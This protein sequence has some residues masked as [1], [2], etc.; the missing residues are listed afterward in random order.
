LGRTGTALDLGSGG[1][2]DTHFLIQ[3]GFIVTAVDAAPNANTYIADLKTDDLNF[4]YSSFENFNF[5]QYDL[6]NSSYSLPFVNQQ[7]FPAVWQNIRTAL[8]PSGL[9]VGE[10]FGIHDPWNNFD[11]QMNFHT[12]QDIEQL[13]NG[14]KIHHLVEEE[15]DRPTASGDRKHW[16]VFHIIAQKK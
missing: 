4:V 5:N 15:N 6:I 10:L 3:Q 8:K 11:G 12:R 1:G 7:D 2:R 13:L 16:H 9:F 14:L